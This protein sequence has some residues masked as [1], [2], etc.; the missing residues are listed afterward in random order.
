VAI[1]QSEETVRTED[2]ANRNKLALASLF[3]TNISKMKY[4]SMS[5]AL[6]DILNDSNP[7]FWI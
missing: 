4:V 5:N 1:V 7:S 6:I 3:R 2:Q